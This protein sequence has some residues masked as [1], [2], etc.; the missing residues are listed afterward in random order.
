MVPGLA[1]HGRCLALDLAGA[2]ETR[3][4]PER[5]LGLGAQA[6]LVCGFV[7]ALGLER[8]S[9]IGHDSGGSIA[10][11]AA[12]AAPERIEA[13]VLADTEVPGHRPWFVVALQRIAALPGARG[14]L[15]P[16]L[17]SAGLARSPFGFGLCFGDLRHFDFAE[18][19]RTVVAPAASS[20]AAKRSTMRFLEDFDFAEI[21]ASRTDYGR[22]TMPKLLLWGEGDR[23]FPPSQGRRLADML[24]EPVRLETIRTAGLLVHEERPEAWVEKV[25]A[26]LAA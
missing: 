25:G 8:V 3:V 1:A 7:D 14:L 20:E 18:F 15:G 11:G 16:V 13:L 12:L 22:L 19:H 21:D 10:R 23:I 24:P 6:R 2:G 9:L 26:F 5:D 4:E 17:G